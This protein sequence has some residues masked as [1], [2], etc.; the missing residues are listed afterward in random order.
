MLASVSLALAAAGFAP[1]SA[2]LC[3]GTE[4]VQAHGDPLPDVERS[5]VAPVRRAAAA[6]APPDSAVER[7]GGLWQRRSDRWA[8]EWLYAF[9]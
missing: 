9:G 4:L 5:A 7:D 6:R 1:P 3:C 2:G 8:A